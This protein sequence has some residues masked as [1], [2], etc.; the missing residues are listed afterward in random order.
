MAT[1]ALAAEPLTVPSDAD[2]K[3]QPS[4]SFLL[5]DAGRTADVRDRSGSRIFAGKQLMPNGVIG[6]GIFGP[7][8]EKGPL[9]AATARDLSVRKR[10]KAAVG[11]SLRF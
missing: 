1:G 7:K 3:K 8:A 2:Q 5:P 9:S 11:F 6:I 10:R 4:R